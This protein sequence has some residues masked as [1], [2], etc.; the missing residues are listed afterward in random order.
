VVEGPARGQSFR[1]PSAPTTIG[2][3]QALI[4]FPDDAFVSPVHA[5]LS[6]R[7]GRLFI[8]DDSSV[9]GTFVAIVNQEPLPANSYFSVGQRLFFFAGAIDQPGP[10][11]AGRAIPY[12]APIPPGQLHCRIDEI[13]VGGRQGRSIL[14]AGPSV[15]VG[16]AAA[17]LSFPNDARLAPRHCELSLSEQGTV[18]RDL[19]GGLGTYIRLPMG[20]ERPLRPGDRFR[21]GQ[22]IIQVEQLNA[23]SA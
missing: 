13:L 9:S 18:L 7:D 15:V 4:L 14:S 23:A 16:Q 12:G 8:R 6:T 3:S 20:V 19:S 11:A 5:T 22:Q 1:L 21:I 17:E 10:T 2:R